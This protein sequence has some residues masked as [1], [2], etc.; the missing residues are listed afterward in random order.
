MISNV[1]NENPGVS[2]ILM[3]KKVVLIAR[4]SDV[5]QRQAL[6]AQKLR[7]QNY[8]QEFETSRT[9][10]FEFDESAYKDSRQK[11]AELIQKI[12]SVRLPL[13]WTHSL[14]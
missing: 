8:A 13:K 6:P 5:E 1:V 12:Q 14:N 4:V 9:Q 3:N 10:Y 7:M 2:G 11:F